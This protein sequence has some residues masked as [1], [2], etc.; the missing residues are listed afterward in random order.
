M[1]AQ[2]VAAAL[3]DILLIPYGVAEWSPDGLAVDGLSARTLR[4]RTAFPCAAINRAAREPLRFNTSRYEAGFAPT[5]QAGAADDATLVKDYLTGLCRP[6]DKLAVQFLDAYF[7][8][9]SDLIEEH[10]DVLSARLAPFAGLYKPADWL[11]SAP[12]PLPR[13]HL[14]APQESGAASAAAISTADFVRVDF[15]FWLGDRLVAAQS[16]QSALTPK[17]AKEQADRLRVAGIETITFAA[18]D[19]TGAKARDLFT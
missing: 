14:H 9:A 1:S 2:V 10:R 16:S 6:W 13:A 19:L 7:R 8:F 18:G 11:F 5:A 3:T 15:A 17:K 12:K 4:L